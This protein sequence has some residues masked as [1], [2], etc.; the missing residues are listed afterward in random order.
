[1]EGTITPFCN[2]KCSLL[3]IGMMVNRYKNEIITD[4]NNLATSGAVHFTGIFPPDV[5]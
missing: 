3:R 5:M 1:M 4:D 2:Y